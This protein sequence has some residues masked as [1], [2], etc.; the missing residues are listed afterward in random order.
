MILPIAVLQILALSP[1]GAPHVAAGSH[2]QDAQWQQDLAA[3]DAELAKRQAAFASLHL[4]GET[5]EDAK[6]ILSHLCDLDQYA[7]KYLAAPYEHRYGGTLAGT[8]FSESFLPRLAR[9][10]AVNLRGLK[11][12]LDKWG[13]FNRATWGDKADNEAW[14]LVQHADHDLLFQKRVL[15]LLEP[16]VG[17][18]GTNPSG[19]AYL[20][21]RVA[22]NER[23]L[24]R[25]GTQG[26][27][28]GPGKWTPRP[29]EDPEHVDARRAAV[30]LRP[31]AEYIASFKDICHEDETRRALQALGQ[32]PQAP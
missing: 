3:F 4:S 14:L 25:F 30:G 17:S 28:I 2:N 6:Q 26:Y 20:F 8:K 16:L 23:H 1:Q 31:L 22:V 18:G 27:C 10:D 29:I 12:L 32:P 24:Q 7:R 21:D 11:S 13:W 15:A 19:F 5:K 9:I